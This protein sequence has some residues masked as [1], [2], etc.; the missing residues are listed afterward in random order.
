MKSSFPTARIYNGLRRLRKDNTGYDFKDLFLG[1]EGT[2]GII[3]AVVLKLFPA[4]K[5][6]ETA[7]CC[8]NSIQDAGKLLNR[9]KMKAGS[10]LTA[11]ELISDLPIERVKKYLPDIEVPPLSDSPWKV[12]VELSL[13][14]KPQESMMEHILEGAFEDGEITDAAI[15]SSLQDSHTFWH[16]RESI[17]LADRT[18]GGSI[19]SDVSLP[20][21]LIPEF[22]EETSAMLLPLI[23]GSGFLSMGTW[24]T[25]TFISISSVPKTRVQPTEMKKEFEK[26]FIVRLINSRARF[27]PNTASEC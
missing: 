18:A 8:L 15:A 7:F 21:S 6:K 10:S 1:S 17:P 3:T 2:I 23:P 27:Q 22:V 12:L 24:A 13:E 14:K 25:E 4:A 20:I 26:F 5:E 19:H 9:F 11:F 16:V